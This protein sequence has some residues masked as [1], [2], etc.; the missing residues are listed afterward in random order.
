MSDNI[1]TSIADAM[2]A[3]RMISVA[4]LKPR[5]FKSWTDETMNYLSLKP[6]NNLHVIFD[7]YNYE[8]S[9]PSKQR[10]VSQMER[11]IK[12]LNQDVPPTK[13][14]NEFLMNY[15]NKSQI[16]NLLVDYIKSAR[17]RDKAVNQ[18]SRKLST[19]DLSVFKQSV[20]MTVL[21][22]QNLILCTGKLIKKFPCTLFMLAGKTMIEFASLPMIEISI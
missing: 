15:K 6:G 2:R 13:E 10:D 11:V 14:W 5:T 18:L 9:V 8:Y 16:D 3:I 22:F 7:N 20:A 21:V 12:S 4:G 17:I 1:S 19:K